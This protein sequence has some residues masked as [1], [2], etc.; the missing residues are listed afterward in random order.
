M[1]YADVSFLKFNSKTMGKTHPNPDDTDPST[2]DGLNLG[3]APVTVRG[4]DRRDELG[5]AE[6]THERD[7]GSLHEE[8]PVRTRDEDERLRDDGNLEVHN[9]VQL[10]VV[11]VHRVRRERHAKLVLEEVGLKDRAHQGNATV[12]K[13]QSARAK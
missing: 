12:P 2:R 5:D 7:R 11:V 10:R 6:S 3:E 9:H 13:N 4:N 8:E 1:F